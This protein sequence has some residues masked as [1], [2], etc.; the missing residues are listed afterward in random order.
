MS[1]HKAHTKDRIDMIRDCM[2]FR[3]ISSRSEMPTSKKIA[4]FPKLSTIC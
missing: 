3:F 2:K 4:M 1:V